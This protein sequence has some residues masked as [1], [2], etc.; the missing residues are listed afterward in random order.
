ML[1]LN[2]SSDEIEA[3]W[4]RLSNAERKTF[5]TMALKAKVEALEAALE[6]RGTPLAVGLPVSMRQLRAWQDHARGL[7]KLRSPSTTDPNKAP[8][9]GDLITRAYTAMETIARRRSGAKLRVY[10]P[11]SK[12]AEN[13]K[14][15]RDALKLENQRLACQVLMLTHERNEAVKKR[16]DLEGES[17]RVVSD[18]AALRRDYLR[19]TKAQIRSVT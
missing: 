4:P 19:V 11:A 3:A 8:H 10:V 15:E 13:R 1:P 14:E 9:N 18:L 2:A 12:L 5:A 17:Q 6:D 7:R 16:V